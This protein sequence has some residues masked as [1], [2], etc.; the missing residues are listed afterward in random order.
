M[1]GTNSHLLVLPTPSPVN[2]VSPKTAVF[3]ETLFQ[4]CPV[5]SMWYVL[6]VCWDLWRVSLYMV[7]LHT[8]CVS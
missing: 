4:H 3:P 1:L 6:G 8:W 7:W 5:G 2:A